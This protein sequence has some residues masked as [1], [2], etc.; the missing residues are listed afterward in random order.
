MLCCGA[1]LSGWDMFE[2]TGKRPE[3]FAQIIQCPEET[4]TDLLQRLTLAI[5]RRVSDPEARKELIKSLVFK[6]LTPNAKR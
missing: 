4:F 1:A 6:T 2:E 3:P 5:N